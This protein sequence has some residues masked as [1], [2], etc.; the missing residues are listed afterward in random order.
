MKRIISLY[1]MLNKNNAA[2]DDKGGSKSILYIII[3]VVVAILLGAAGYKFA[4][5]IEVVGGVS[6]TLSFG[7]F[8]AGVVM[9]ALGFFTMINSMY[10]SSDIELL[11]T[12]PLSSFEIVILRIISFLKLAYGVCLAVIIPINLGYSFVKTTTAI[13]WTA[14]ILVFIL[15]PI[16]MTMITATV[17]ILIMSLVK[18]FRNMDVLRYIGIIAAFVLLCAY[19]YFSGGDNK[20]IDATSIITQVAQFGATTKYVVPISGFLVDFL[21]TSNVI[22]ILIDL[23]IM[24]GVVLLFVFVAKTLYLQGALNMQNTAIGGKILDDEALRKAS[25]KKDVLKA[26]ISKEFKLVRRNPTYSLNNFIIGFLWPILAIVLFRTLASSVMA[27]FAAQEATMSQTYLNIEFTLY[28]SAAL[29][30]IIL[31]IPMLYSTIAYS[32]LSREGKSFPVMK[33]IPVPYE[34]QIKAKLSI[35]ERLHQITTT[36]YVAII[37]I[38]LDIIYNVPVYYALIPVVITFFT[39][40]VF[41]YAD[42]LAGYKGATVNWDDEKTAASKNNAGLIVMYIMVALAM[43]ILLIGGANVFPNDQPML[44]L[45]IP[46]VITAVMVVLR[47]VLKKSVFK[48]G[49]KKIRSLRF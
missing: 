3:G 9:L 5:I 18:L 40:E 28:V 49:E 7:G 42:M 25:T 8:V 30:F 2:G 46:A 36:L 4:D 37:T 48:K 26:L 38:V 41:I 17:I 39:V 44:M 16:F 11:I 20:S 24:V 21:L 1:K 33:Q 15:E 19:F 47:V 14:I 12:M 23:A 31:I 32:S 22:D 43:V 27:T 10:M 13:E 34:V 6:A 35:A 45:I 29:I